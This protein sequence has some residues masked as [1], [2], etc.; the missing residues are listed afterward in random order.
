MKNVI[1]RY[2][3]KLMPVKKIEVPIMAQ[4]PSNTFLKDRN[5][6]ITGGTGGIGLAIATRMGQ[7]GANV[8]LAGRNVEKLKKS[9]GVNSYIALD[10]SDV[11]SLQEKLNQAEE[12]AAGKIEL[13]VNCAGIQ[14]PSEYAG[15]GFLDIEENDWDC[16]MD[17][18]LKG[19]Y[20]MCQAFAKKCIKNKTSAK[21]INICSVTGLMPRTTPYGISKWGVVDI[22]RSLAVQLAKYGITV[23]GVAPGLTNTVMT[24]SMFSE[25]NNIY[26]ED[27][28]DKRCA[29]PDDIA[30]IVLFL[31][32]D[33]SAHINGEV[34]VCDGG[35]ICQ[36]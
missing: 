1:S 35:K 17:V 11:S 36:Q 12:K 16:V 8:I 18:N 13:L 29:T 30:N 15:K 28:P 31:A 2:I 4:S 24:S 5:V 25:I 14:S 26:R 34:I 20:F 21:I 23:N 32:S 7:A 22:T 27:H 33:Y 9:G 6:L 10:I 19:T 3:G